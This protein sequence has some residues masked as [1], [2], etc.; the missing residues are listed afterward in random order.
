MKRLERLVFVL[1]TSLMCSDSIFKL[2]KR[3]TD[4]SFYLYAKRW[5][6]LFYLTW[7]W[8]SKFRCPPNRHTDLKSGLDQPLLYNMRYFLHS[9][10]IEFCELDI[11]LCFNVLD[12]NVGL[13]PSVFKKVFWTILTKNKVKI[14]VNILWF[15]I[16]NHTFANEQKWHVGKLRSWVIIIVPHVKWILLYFYG[17]HSNGALKTTLSV[18]FFLIFLLP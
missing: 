10:L 18:L 4:G 6:F 17:C 5:L 16:K 12:Y 15:V 8:A 1:F 13:N 3:V 11:P 2:L 14:V 9:I 7:I